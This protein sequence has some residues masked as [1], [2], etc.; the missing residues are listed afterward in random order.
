VA[1]EGFLGPVRGSSEAAWIPVTGTAVAGDNAF[2]R[3]TVSWLDVLG[4]LMPGMDSTRAQA[5]LDLLGTQ[6]ARD[7]LFS[8][9]SRLTMADGSLGFTYLVS[10]LR[11]P[12]SVLFVAS[13]LVL[14]IAGANL[15]GLLLARATTRQRELSIRLSLGATRWRI[16]R[17]FLAEGVMLAL[18]GAAAGLLVAAW[19]GNV[20]PAVRTLFG[21]ELQLSGGIDLRT[22]LVTGLLSLVL[23]ACIAASPVSWASTLELSR[24]IKD[25]GG[26]G[27]PGGAL[28]GRLVTAQLALAVVLVAG[29][30]LLSVTTRKLS[31]VNPG[32]DPSGVMLAG[33]DLGARGYNG[34]RARQFWEN[35]ITDLSATPQIAGASVAQ[36]VTPSPGGIHYDQVGLEGS[37]VLPAQVEFDLN[38]VGPGYF[39]TLG[40]PVSQGRGFTNDDRRGA[41]A[42]AVIN[43]AMAKKYWA[44]QSP[45]GRHMWFDGDST[46]PGITVVGIVPDGKYRSLREDPLPAVFLPALQQAPIN[47]TLLVRSRN[48]VS[49][50]TV[51]GLI[52]ASVRRLD[53]GVPVYDLRPL[54][55]HLSL[56]SAT[57]RLLSFLATMYAA[58]ATVLAAVGL[59]GV[60]TY[61]VARRT[62]EIGIRLALGAEPARIRREVVRQGLVHGVVGVV[63]GLGLSLGASR[64]VGALLYDV[65]PLNPLILIGVSAVMLVVTLTAS[66]WPAARAARVDP[67]VALRSE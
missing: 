29:G 23:A 11:R 60:L 38:D 26:S 39:S 42:V 4:R 43:Q 32:Y 31:R 17:L 12:L 58:L 9:T 22:A 21:Q 54:S 20:S 27:T 59:F 40:I 33:V 13:G 5:G 10:D 45:L 47:G 55:A 44:G 34:E 52:R 49:E 61:H 14:L 46:K 66:W 48:G 7:S 15:A 65:S 36:I 62:N 53:P 18:F 3:R 50:S 30:L 19:I 63:L 24:G 41:E 2:T 35:V 51:A 25:G 1:P 28:R 37:A 67:M 16:A 8:S 57:E 64:W 56:A 6:L